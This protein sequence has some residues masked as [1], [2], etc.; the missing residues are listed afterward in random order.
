MTVS[1]AVPSAEAQRVEPTEHPFPL[2]QWYVAAMGWELKD[3]P[4]GRT[5]LNK[6]VVLFRTA[7]GQ[8][9]A[10]ENRCCHR[11]L[12]LSDGTLEATG[13]RC[14]Y[15]GLLFDG[16]GRCIEV[17]GQEKIPSKAIVPAWPVQERDQIVWIWFGSEA[18]PQPTHEPPAYEVHSSGQYLFDGDVFHYNAPWQLIHDNLMDLSHLGYV[19]LKTIG[20]NASIHMNAQMKV[21]QE[22]DTVRVIRHMPGSVPPPTYTAAYPFK[23]KID[24][25]QEIEFFFNHLRIWTGAVDEGTESLD[26]PTRGGFHMRGFH[27][28]TPETDTSCH[29]FWSM[30]TNPTQDH[31]EVKAKVI[32]QTALTFMEDKVVIESQYRNICQFGSPPMVDI[33]VDVGANRARRV[34][35]RLRGAA[36]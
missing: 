7:D 21:E 19:H 25:W 30:A 17:P 26:D 11:A 16:A 23:G 4:I 24:R 2:D 15:H 12:P 35:D 10:L 9:A 34:I 3:K 1:I 28:I 18:H 29:Y 13:I 27:G 31:E 5:L 32:E 8:V 6:S 20:G 22:G 36:R 33:H 14:G